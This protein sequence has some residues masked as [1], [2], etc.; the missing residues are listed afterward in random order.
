MAKIN[1]KQMIIGFVLVC[2]AIFGLFCYLSYVRYY[3]IEAL[4]VTNKSKED[5]IQKEEQKLREIDKFNIEISH[6]RR[7]YNQYAEVLPDDKK[8]EEFLQAIR[9]ITEDLG[10]PPTNLLTTNSKDKTK[11]ANELAGVSVEMKFEA[12]YEQAG[13]FMNKIEGYQRFISISDLKLDSKDSIPPKTA[14]ASSTSDGKND[15]IVVPE[16]MILDVSMK[17]NTYIYNEPVEQDQQ[18]L[19]NTTPGIS[20]IK[21][22]AEWTPD[23]SRDPFVYV[24]QLK[25]INK[26]ETA[27]GK[28]EPAENPEDGICQY[29]EED[30]RCTIKKNGISDFCQKH[31]KII[32]DNGKEDTTLAKAKELLQKIED[33][34]DKGDQKALTKHYQEMDQV[35]LYPFKLD[36]I[37]IEIE[38]VRQ[39]YHKIKQDN[40]DKNRAIILKK[41]LGSKS[42][43][44]SLFLEGKYEDCMAEYKQL[45]TLLSVDSGTIDPEFHTILSEARNLKEKAKIHLEF[46]DLALEIAGIIW[47]Q[48]HPEESVAIIDGATKSVDDYV[49]YGARIV[50]I[51][52]GEVV[53]S[54][55]GENIARKFQEKF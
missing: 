31:F 49:N 27:T 1:E 33:A 36:W 42:L 13:Q 19:L 40:R 14:N 32:D 11:S 52:K 24:V 6:L 18:G 41:S 16:K 48:K 47:I 39:R 3:E 23:A 50:E 45:T 44:L 12:T 53:F 34:F 25:K 17:L 26:E 2:L 8:L 10:I 54:Y 55:K 29:Y 35:L 7:E 43:M 51:R 22:V 4:K 9:E 37:K 21:K 30:K 20:N 15:H 46:A 28:E 38:G 5:L